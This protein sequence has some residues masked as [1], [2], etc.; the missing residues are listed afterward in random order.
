MYLIKIFGVL[1]IVIC[2]TLIGTIKS[3][4]LHK[5]HKKLS[6]LLDGVNTLYNHIEQGEFELKTAIKNAFCKCRFL[7]FS[8]LKVLCEDSDLK[9]DKTLIEDFFASLGRAT[10][11]IECEHI[12]HFAIKLKSGLKDAENDVI[13]KC[14]IYQILGICSGLVL[15]ILFI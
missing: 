10:K 9:K 12:N 4:S 5:R 11:K 8:G 6:L 2:S 1:L 15:G 3:K 14:K 13:N 7:N